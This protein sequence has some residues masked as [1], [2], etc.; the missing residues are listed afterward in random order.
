MHRV[1]RRPGAPTSRGQA[2]VE[3]ALIVPL[4]IMVLTG[5]IVLGLIVFF[6]QQLS[7]AAREG[8]RF[9]AIGSASAQC[10]VVSTIR[11]PN[12]DSLGFT[13]AWAPP[14]SY[15]DCD[16]KPWPKMVAFA[17]SKVFGVNPA[18][19]LVSACWSGYRTPANDPV[20][21]SHYDAPPPAPSPGYLINGNPTVINSSW[22]QCT[23]NGVDPTGNTSAIPCQSG[24]STTDTASD[25]S[26]GQGRIVANRVTV[27]ACMAWSPPMAGF[28]LIPQRV[29]LRAVISEPIQRQQ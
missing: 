5:I 8:A 4:F 14:P 3:F 6:N 13:G 26:E 23:I 24:L 11:P 22:A 17:R 18:S 7:N 9:A 28:L 19:V 27:F 15:V 1:L 29:T 12:V 2:L 25:M 10:P 20:F 21:P 16:P